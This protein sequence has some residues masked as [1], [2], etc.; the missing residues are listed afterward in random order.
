M[1]TYEYECEKCR[2]RFDR[3]QS[4]NEPPIRRCPLCNGKVSRLISTGAAVIFRGPGFYATDYRSDDYR[5]K[6]KEEKKT[7]DKKEDSKET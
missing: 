1:P 4:I 6:E 5:K 3:F 2:Y 7:E